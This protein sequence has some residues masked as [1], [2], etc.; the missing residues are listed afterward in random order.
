MAQPSSSSVVPTPVANGVPT[1]AGQT[2]VAPADLDDAALFQ[3][4]NARF[5][6]FGGNARQYQLLFLN[7]RF[8]SLPAYVLSLFRHIAFFVSVCVSLMWSYKRVSTPVRSSSSSKALRLYGGGNNDNANGASTSYS[9]PAP[10][11][12]VEEVTHSSGYSDMSIS[13]FRAALDAQISRDGLVSCLTDYKPN[14]APLPVSAM[15]LQKIRSA[16]SDCDDTQVMSTYYR[17]LETPT[18]GDYH[19]RFVEYLSEHN[20]R[21]YLPFLTDHVMES[22]FACSLTFSELLSN[23]RDAAGEC[24]VCGE[25]TSR[26]CSVSND[27]WYCC[28][29]HQEYDQYAHYYRT[30]G[31]CGLPLPEEDTGGLTLELNLPSCCRGTRRSARALQPDVRLPP[32]QGFGGG[33]SH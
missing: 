19:D 11:P 8:S 14:V 13:Q 2:P 23:L 9:P 21:V 24:E 15:N 26:R 6:Q 29:G 16:L 7:D 22:A 10:I 1:N 28:M 32:P 30:Q 33:R 20:L 4:F 27:E 3:A 17:S 5:P 31:R 12:T 25:L 18:L